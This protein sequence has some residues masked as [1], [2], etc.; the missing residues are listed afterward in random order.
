MTL[1]FTLSISPVLF[2]VLFAASL[3]LVIRHKMQPVGDRGRK[4]TVV[5]GLAYL[6]LF[7]LTSVGVLFLLGNLVLN[8]TNGGNL[9][10]W[11]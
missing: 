2:F 11:F 3:L 7:F 9:L 1:F 6:S 5:D 4:V 8:L 10:G